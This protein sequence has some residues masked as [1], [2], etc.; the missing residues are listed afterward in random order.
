MIKN[1]SKAIYSQCEYGPIFGD[2]DIY[3][4]FDC[5]KLNV[6]YIAFKGTY[7]CN[8][9]SLFVG[10]IESKGE[11]ISFTVLDYEVYCIANYKDYINN[12]CKYPAIIW[13]YLKKK[14]ITK[15]SLKKIDNEDEFRNDL[16]SIHCLDKTFLFKFYRHF[17]KTPSKLLPKTQIVNKE[18]D[19]YLREWLGNNHKWKLI[20]RASEHGYSGESFHQCCDD[21]GPTLVIIRSIDGWIF[22]GYTTQ[23][24]SREGI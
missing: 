2:H 8:D 21:K 15:E 16:D 11:M 3:I 24:W 6:N 20:Y 19:S 14:D 12:I 13:E 7:E 23:S 5:N 1:P 10:D 18:Y 17:F 4:D 9:S 22:G